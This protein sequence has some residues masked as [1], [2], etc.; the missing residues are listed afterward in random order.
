MDKVLE[1]IIESTGKTPIVKL[2]K[3]SASLPANIIG[4]VESFNP[5]GSI[6]DRI[7][8]SMIEYGE[9]TGKITED[10][11]IIEPTSGNTGIALSFICAVKGYRLILTM[12]ETVNIEKKK[13]LKAMGAD[14]ILTPA[15]QGMK[16]AVLRAEQEA[17]KIN[18]T[19][20]PN[21]FKNPA[22]PEIHRKTT[23]EEIW[24]QTEGNID[25]LVSGV[26]TG[27]TITGITELIKSRK[28]DFY[29]V[30]V[31]PEESPVLSGG[32]PGSHKIQ[33]IGAGFIP[34]IL[35]TEIID[36]IICVSME[37]AKKG[38]R[39]LARKEGMFMGISS[40]AAVHAAVQIAKRTRNKDKN[41]V[42]ILPDSGDRYLSTNLYEE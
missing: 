19:Y 41:I 35:N 23:G 8:L 38:S 10:T 3:I 40:G 29:S 34:D 39:D 28:P 11:V 37:Q 24:Q 25:I 18:D 26:G 4:K 1:N 30:A 12:P 9:K 36:E 14:I 17:E 16:G 31:E 21:Q 2:K 5:L 22:N 27:G 7:G 6:K 33:G 32:S 15:D 20:L 13:I 42:V